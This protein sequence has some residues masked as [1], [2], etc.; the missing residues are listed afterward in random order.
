MSDNQEVL[1][2]CQ[3]SRGGFDHERKFILEAPGGGRYTG[4]AYIEYCFDSSKRPL[5]P[6]EPPRGSIAPGFLVAR[7]LAKDGS[8][9]TVS[10]PDGETCDVSADVVEG[11]YQGV[12]IQS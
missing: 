9:Y 5:H 6:D 7:I 1:L 12:L 8:I 3:F 4:I 10:V 2:R 11:E